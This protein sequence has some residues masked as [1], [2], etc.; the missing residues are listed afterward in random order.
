[1]KT[2][3]SIR[4]YLSSQAARPSGAFGRLLGRIWPMETA[5]VNRI[6]V[7][8]LEPAPGERICE[9]GFGPGR[10]LGLL[11]AVGAEVIGVEVSDTMMTIAARRN[12][13]Y[14]ATG[15]I[16]L[17]RGDGTTLPIADRSVDKVISVHNFYFW[18][19]PSASLSD[20]HRTLRPG[21]R[22]V[23]TSLST[24][25]P[26]PTRFDPS[27]YRVPTLDH[28]LEWLRLV[29]FSNIGIERRPDHPSTVWLSATAT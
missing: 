8:L 2:S 24:D 3:R 7:E 18:P 13:K 26:L 11:A 10:T 19:D 6:A 27:I 4:R 28:T 12:A 9:I 29:G 14:I 1:M 16:S 25:Q 20:I 5:G 23:L 17:Y 21:G 22:L 15:L